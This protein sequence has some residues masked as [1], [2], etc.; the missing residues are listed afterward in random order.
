MGYTAHLTRTVRCV[1]T[2]TNVIQGHASHLL[3]SPPVTKLSCSLQLRLL[4]VSLSLSPSLPLPL[5]EPIVIDAKEYN[6]LAPSDMSARLSLYSPEAV[7]NY[8][9]SQ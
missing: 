9:Q 8:Q 4:D 5:D 7:Y 2:I 1:W 6:E 3:S